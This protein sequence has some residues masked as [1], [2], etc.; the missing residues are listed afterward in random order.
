[1]MTTKRQPQKWDSKW[2]DQVKSRGPRM[3]NIMK[4]QDNLLSTL[5]DIRSKK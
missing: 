1:M 3:V 4:S 2:F 5:K